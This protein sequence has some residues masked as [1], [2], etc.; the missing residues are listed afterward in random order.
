MFIFGMG[1]SDGL[2]TGSLENI[3]AQPEGAFKEDGLGD[4]SNERENFFSPKMG[5]LRRIERLG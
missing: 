3:L 1:L 5:R 4:Y 2:R